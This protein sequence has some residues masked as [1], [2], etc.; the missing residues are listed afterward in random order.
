MAEYLAEYNLLDCRVLLEAIEVY[1]Q[2]FYDSWK[3]DIHQSLSLPSISQKLAYKLYNK[4]APPIVTFGKKFS[5]YNADIR[6]QLFGGMT[7]LRV[8]KYI[9]FILFNPDKPD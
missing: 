6:S 9:I 5:Q 1:A 8:F 7:L 2:G 3:V 4:N